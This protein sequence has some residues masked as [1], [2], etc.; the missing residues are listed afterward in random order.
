MDIIISYISIFKVPENC[1]SCYT[2]KENVVTL[3]IYYLKLAS[4]SWCIYTYVSP[5]F[6]QLA[7]Y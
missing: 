2:F 3:T 6:L 1:N 5:V 7:E 4:S